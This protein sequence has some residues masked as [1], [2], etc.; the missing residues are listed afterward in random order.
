MDYKVLGLV[1]PKG[2]ILEP[3]RETRP[4]SVVF[5]MESVLFRGSLKA[6]E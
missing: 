2:E 5:F 6:S 1:Q 3:L 4:H